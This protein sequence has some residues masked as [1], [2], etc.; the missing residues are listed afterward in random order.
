[1]SSFKQRFLAQRASGAGQGGAGKVPSPEK[2]P[3]TGIPKDRY[4]RKTIDEVFGGTDA[5][6][7]LHRNAELTKAAATSDRTKATYAPAVTNWIYFC[8][9]AHIAPHPVDPVLMEQFLALRRTASAANVDLA[10]IAK[11]FPFT[12]T[13]GMADILKGLSHTQEPPAQ[14]VGVT[15]KFLKQMVGCI[16]LSAQEKCCLILGWFGL[17]RIGDEAVPLRKAKMGQKSLNGAHSAVSIEKDCIAVELA[18]RKNAQFGGTIRR[19]CNCS[20]DPEVCPAHSCINLLAKTSA[21]ERLFPTLTYEKMLSL[22]RKLALRFKYRLDA[23]IG[24]HSLRRGALQHMQTQ[25]RGL[26]EQKAAGAWRSGKTVKRSYQD[27]V[28]AEEQDALPLF[29]DENGLSEVEDEEAL[30]I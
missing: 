20:Q 11:V 17:M 13:K 8:D 23:K 7:R 6:E 12:R 21:G 15:K 27:K 10:A 14:V 25:K 18:S 24:T 22:I 19:A 4:I 2:A 3:A 28:V 26:P 29:E 5:K 16:D 30:L 1:M 9:R